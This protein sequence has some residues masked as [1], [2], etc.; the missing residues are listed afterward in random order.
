M[1]VSYPPLLHSPYLLLP[2][3][4]QELAKRAPVTAGAQK[5]HPIAILFPYPLLPRT[6]QE[7]TKKDPVPS[8]L[9]DMIQAFTFELNH[10]PNALITNLSNGLSPE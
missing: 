1:V 5:Y 9:G 7:L 4:K 10:L 3:T 8:W 2:R 6:K